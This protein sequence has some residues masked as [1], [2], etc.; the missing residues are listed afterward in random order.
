MQILIIIQNQ[1]HYL[2]PPFQNYAKISLEVTWNYFRF[3]YL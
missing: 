2:L 3:N 1:F